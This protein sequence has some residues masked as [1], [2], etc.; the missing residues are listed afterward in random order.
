M[1]NPNCSNLS[2]V[3]MISPKA[4]PIFFNSG[5][6]ANRV[7]QRKARLENNASICPRKDTGRGF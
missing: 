3:F 4:P 2:D 5:Q 7:N 6:F 1:C